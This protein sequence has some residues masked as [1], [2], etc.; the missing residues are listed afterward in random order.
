MTDE[1][2]EW[3]REFPIL[4]GAVYLISHSLGAMP[5]RAQE[6]LQAYAETWATRGVRAWAEGWWEMPLAVGDE[7][8]R[9]IGAD[10]GAVVMHQNV[11]VCQSIILS[12]FDTTPQTRRNKIVYS[13]LEFPSV[14]YVYEAH[15][16]DGRFRIHKVKSEDGVTAPLEATLAAIDEET[17]LVPLSHVLFKSASLQDARAITRRA[18]EVG[19]LVVLDTYQSAGTVPFSVKDLDVDFCTGGSVK[20]LCGGPGAGYLYVAPRLRRQLE[21]KVTGWMAHAAPFSFEDGPI[22]YSEGA[23]RFLHGSPAVPALYAAESGYKI[24][25]E[26]GVERIREKSVRQTQALI[27]LAEEAGLRVTS[28]RD[29]ARRGGTITV[30]ADHAPAV[31]RELIRREFIVD[32]RPGAGVRISPH[33][34]TKDE[35]LELVVREMRQ[36]LDTRAYAEH[37]AAGAAF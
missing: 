11:S 33:F 7:V 15:A 2:L 23:A 28:P 8:A 35:E 14:M 13:E 10:P 31:T 24:I 36:I 37:E 34:Y 16:R 1:L 22:H 25:N 20:W 18:H 32:Y 5:R 4:E 9:I 19:A 30:A 3:R 26:I 12:C 6:R 27:G 21:P 29:P 17:L